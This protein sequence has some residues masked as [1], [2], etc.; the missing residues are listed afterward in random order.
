M[1]QDG[2]Q[3]LRLAK[4]KIEGTEWGEHF[5][6]FNAV[7]WERHD[8]EIAERLNNP[9]VIEEASLDRLALWGFILHLKNEWS[10]NKD[11]EHIREFL[12][13]SE[14]NDMF[15]LLEL[16]EDIKTKQRIHRHYV[17]DL[18]VGKNENN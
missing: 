9:P 4:Q 14:W 11:Y 7:D 17:N 15:D 6:E 12:K 2:S 5:A 18:L 13:Y 3:I 8:R 10:G 1:T 16:A